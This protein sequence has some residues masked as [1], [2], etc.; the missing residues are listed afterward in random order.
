MVSVRSKDGTSVVNNFERSEE[1][2]DAALRLRTPDTECV[3]L[4]MT[5]GATEVEFDFDAPRVGEALQLALLGAPHWTGPNVAAQV[6]VTPER[7]RAAFD[8]LREAGFL[9]VTGRGTTE[10]T[11]HFAHGAPQV[12]D[13]LRELAERRGID[14]DAPL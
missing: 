14:L 5:H 11:W 6:G 2:R 10:E 1:A 3:R 12:F 13:G 9:D 7:L 8:P 4:T